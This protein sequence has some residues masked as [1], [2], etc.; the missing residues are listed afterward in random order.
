MPLWLVREHN[1]P[2]NSTLIGWTLST[3][4]LAAAFGGIVGGLV[5]NKIGTKRLVVGSLLIALLP[6]YTI[7]FLAPGSPI[8]F[9]MV[10]LAGALVNAGMPMLIVT[11]QDHS[12]KASATAAGMLMGFSTGVAG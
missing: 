11:A 2:N 8:Y 7:F 10:F 9:A 12:P 1:L 4:S 3:F 6:L 5:S